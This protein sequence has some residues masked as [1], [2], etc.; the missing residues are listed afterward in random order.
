MRLESQVAN[1]PPNRV[2][3]MF[4]TYESVNDNATRQ[5]G[6]PHRQTVAIDSQFDPLTPNGIQ[7]RCA[8]G[9]LEQYAARRFPDNDHVGNSNQR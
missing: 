1:R 6:G 2:N 5:I 4:A 9:E 7:P 8:T 3:S